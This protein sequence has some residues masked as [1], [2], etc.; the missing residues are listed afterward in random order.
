M[1]FCSTSKVGFPPFATF[2]DARVCVVDIQVTGCSWLQACIPTRDLDL[3]YLM[4]P[5]HGGEGSF[6]M[7]DHGRFRFLSVA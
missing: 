7:I 1:L 5:S 3:S 4:L 6:L 2:V